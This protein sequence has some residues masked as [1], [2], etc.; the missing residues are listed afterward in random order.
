[1]V[2][3][4]AR[5][6]AAD[7]DAVEVESFERGR[8][9]ISIK[10]KMAEGDVGKLIGKGGRNIEAVRALIRIAS[11]REHRRVFVDLA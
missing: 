8:G 2:E 7:P 9:G 10:V 6:V 1:M 11:M 3:F 4:I 5:S